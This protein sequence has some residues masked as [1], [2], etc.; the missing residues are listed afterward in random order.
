MLEPRRRHYLAQF[1]GANDNP[2]DR[3]RKTNLVARAIYPRAGVKSYC[4]L[5]VR[6]VGLNEQGAILQSSAIE[7]LP[8]HFYLCLGEEEIFLT[9]AKKSV[10]K[11]DMFVTFARPESAELVESLT[12]MPFPL[13]TLRRLSGRC[14][15]VIEARIARGKRMN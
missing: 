7:F 9:C 10:L 8:D 6:I 15:P 12:R 11:A 4:S 1:Y 14:E 2:H 3:Y 5:Q 13:G